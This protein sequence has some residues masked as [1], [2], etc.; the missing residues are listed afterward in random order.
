MA[1]LPA[2]ERANLYEQTTRCVRPE[3]DRWPP[4]TFFGCGEL[5]ARRVVADA[6][7]KAKPDNPPAGLDNQYPKLAGERRFRGKSRL[8]YAPLRELR[9]IQ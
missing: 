6:G 7:L 4:E 2:L 9:S 5:R 3:A 8:R 1:P